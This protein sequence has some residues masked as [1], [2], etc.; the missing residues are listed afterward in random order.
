[1]TSRNEYNY[2]DL[3]AEVGYGK[4]KF[5]VAVQSGDTR[6]FTAS[7]ESPPEQ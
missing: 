4:M 5:E 2:S 7:R 6:S 1:M 3:A